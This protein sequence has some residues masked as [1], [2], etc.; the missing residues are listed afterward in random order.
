[1]FV[2][3]TVVFTFIAN[4]SSSCSPLHESHYILGN[5]KLLH[6]GDSISIQE[7]NLNEIIFNQIIRNNLQ[8]FLKLFAEKDSKNEIISFIST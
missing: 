6:A 7:E 1:V 5:L 4:L 3:D 2:H 8:V